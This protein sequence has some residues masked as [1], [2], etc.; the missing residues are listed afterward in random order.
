MRLLIL[1]FSILS[2][3]SVFANPTVRSMR[4][5]P[6]YFYS[7][8][9]NLST[10]EIAEKV[11]ATAKA[12]NVNT[13][14]IYAYNSTYGSF[15][16]T[17]YSMTTIESGY[18]QLDIFGTILNTAKSNG[19]TVIANMPVND[20]KNVWDLKPSWRSKKRNGT[21]YIPAADTYLLSA[22][23]PYFR[24]WLAGFYKDF[25][26]RYP[27]VDAIEAVEPM[28]DYFWNKDSDYNPSSNSEFKLRY[29]AAYLG[30]STWL[31]FRAQGLTNL[32]ASLSQVA[33]A[34]GK[35][36]AVV[37]TWAVNADGSLFTYQSMR[38][39]MG[40]DFNAILNLTGAYKVDFISAEF[41]WQQWK[42]EYGSAIF[43][44]DWTRSASISFLNFVAN[45][46][47]PIIHLEIS[48]FYGSVTSV[49]PT[50]L[51]LQNSIQAIADITPGIDVY[52]YNQIESL[53]AWSAFA[54]W[55]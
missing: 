27:A 55:N 22:W 5:D 54:T 19:L 43:N 21:D 36:S 44:P 13:L 39:G 38:D 7:L 16:T 9:P 41:M 2:S 6:S 3:I 31:R 45:R 37:Q 15:Y 32:V 51:D 46:S 52:D 25:L 24:T 47:F 26:A 11:V 28:V 23:H 17:N 33:H 50:P 12:A 10:L 40:F 30:G 18:G 8:Y 53:S 34:A 1:L 49:T 4:I 29:P 35:K 14:Y 20:F 48:P 42:A